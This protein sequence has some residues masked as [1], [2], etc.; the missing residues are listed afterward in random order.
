MPRT[1]SFDDSEIR[2]ALSESFAMASAITDAA[3]IGQLSRFAA[4]HL[5]II[6]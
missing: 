2:E 1:V 5:S 4:D 6:C 3:R